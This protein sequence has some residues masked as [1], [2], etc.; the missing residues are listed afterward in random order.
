MSPV[1]QNERR[2]DDYLYPF[3]VLDA[4]YIKVREGGRVLSYGVLIG[5][6]VRDDGRREILGLQLNQTES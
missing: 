2:L 3:L 6:G 1:G 4:L 5:T